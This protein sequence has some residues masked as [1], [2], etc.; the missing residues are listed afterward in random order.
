MQ[1]CVLSGALA[2]LYSDYQD[3]VNFLCIYLAEAHPKEKWNFGER[4]SYMEQH[5]TLEDRANAAR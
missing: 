1:A 3:R 2:K 5:K 4:F